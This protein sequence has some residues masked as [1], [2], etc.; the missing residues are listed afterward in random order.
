MFFNKKKKLELQIAEAKAKEAEAK[1]AALKAEESKEYAKLAFIQKLE[2]QT[3][4]QQVNREVTAPFIP[5]GVIPKGKPNAIAMDSACS[6]G[7]YNIAQQH[8][9][10]F[11]LFEGFPKLSFMMQSSD[12]YSVVETTANE[13]TR[14]WGDL[15]VVDGDNTEGQKKRVKALND[16][17]DKDNIKDLFNKHIRNELIFGRSQI[18]IDLGHKDNSDP[19][20]LSNK[21]IE[22]G[23]LKGLSV[24]EPIWSTPSDYNANDPKQSDFYKPDI[25]YVLGESVHSDRLM[26]MVNRPVPDMFKPSYNFSGL[27]ILQLMQPYVERWQRGIDATADLLVSFSISGIKTSLGDVLAGTV[28]SPSDLI[29]RAEMFNRFRDNRNLMLMDKETEEFF[30]FNTP[31]SGVPELLR[32]L[33]E[34]MGAPSHTPLVKLLGIAP[35]GLNASSEGEIRVYYDY[36]SACQESFLLWQIEKLNR[37]YQLHLF[38]DI[39]E[40]IQFVFK[41]L[42]Q[43]NEKEQSE[44]NMYDAQTAQTYIQ[45]GVISREEVRQAVAK[46]EQGQYGFINPADIPED[47]ESNLDYGEEENE[48]LEG[49]QA[50]FGGRGVVRPNSQGN[51]QRN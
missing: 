11:P 29:V 9:Q 3:P 7:A 34:Q 51:S 33:Q 4:V 18:F 12:Y 49:N 45:S 19:L 1:L 23:S 20:V 43:L 8:V 5:E 10:F 46:D 26:T 42:Y 47:T 13:M 24:I 44:K 6:A 2:E 15:R 22:K 21:T 48:S 40:S 17:F 30:Q 50:Q 38:G 28:A 41:P 37:I 16:A 14:E 27:S 39:D 25:W 31:L 36:I 35:S 32:H